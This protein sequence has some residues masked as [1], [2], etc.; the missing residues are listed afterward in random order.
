M[1]VGLCDSCFEVC[2]EVVGF[3]GKLLMFV[4]V[5]EVCINECLEVCIFMEMFIFNI[6]IGEQ[7]IIYKVID[8]LNYIQF[9]FNDLE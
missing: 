8:W 2:Y 3:D 4:E 5:K 7:K 9:L 1:E 6:E